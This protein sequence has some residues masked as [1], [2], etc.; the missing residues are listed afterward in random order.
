MTPPA[1]PSLADPI[2]ADPILFEA[3]TTPP[4][5][6]SRTGMAWLCALTIPAAA[7]PAVLFAMLGAWPVL[8]FMGVE[9]A[10]VLG[11]VA[12]HRRWSA[13]AV[14]S[15]SLSPGLLRVS[16]A[17][18]RGGRAVAEFDPYWTRLTLE[19]RAGIAPALRLTCRGRTLEVGRFLAEAEKRDLAQALENALRRYRNPTF[20]NPQLR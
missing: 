11:L 18:G 20:E 6:L 15:L 19:E 13:A 2:P 8:G 14:E 4:R 17:D 10:M 16:C 5:S 7:V 3:I 9:V 1:D 12:L